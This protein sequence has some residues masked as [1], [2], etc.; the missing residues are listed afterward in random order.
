M[1]RIKHKF[2]QRYVSSKH[3]YCIWTS[4]E[5]DTKSLSSVILKL[6]QRQTFK[7]SEIDFR[8]VRLSS[9]P[10]GGQ[11]MIYGCVGSVRKHQLSPEAAAINLSTFS[12][13][14]SQLPLRWPALASAQLRCLPA[15]KSDEWYGKTKSPIIAT[16]KEQLMLLLMFFAAMLTPR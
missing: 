15:V 7:T 3:F 6:P 16:V 2:R 14:W 1:H 11:L 9:S 13:A 10:P 12:E 4:F 8:G 5:G